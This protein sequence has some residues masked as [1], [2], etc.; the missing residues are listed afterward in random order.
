MKT[1]DFT[2][3]FIARYTTSFQ[4]I[5]SV[6]N[7]FL[8]LKKDQYYLY[9]ALPILAIIYSFQSFSILDKFP[10][11]RSKSIFETFSFMLIKFKSAKNSILVMGFSL[12]ITFIIFHLSL[13]EVKPDL[14]LPAFFFSVICI[15]IDCIFTN[16]LFDGDK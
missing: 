10:E 15:Y 1:S 11:L 2:K 6:V 8:F 5:L 4:L 16:S 9:C 14:I 12:L 3:V 7:N 13:N